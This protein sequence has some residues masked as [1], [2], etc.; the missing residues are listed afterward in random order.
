MDSEISR[1]KFNS[2]LVK[3]LG[4]V[5]ALSAM[6]LGCVTATTGA[7]KKLGV[8][9]VGLGYYSAG[10]LAPALQQTE[11]CEL[12][13]I[14]TGTPSKEKTWI[15][16][17]GIAQENIYNYD[18]FDEIVNNEAIDIVYIVLPNSMHAEFS[19]RA[20]KAGKH[21]ICEKPMAMDVAECEQI[22]KA[23]KDAGV[24]LSVGY[25]L[26]SEPYTN[27]VKRYVQDQTF[28]RP[29]YVSAEA[30]YISGN[31]W[32]QWRFNRTLSGGGALMNMG[33]YAI[34]GVLY[35]TGELPV[36]VT[37]QE[38]STNPK[39]FKETDETITAQFEF[40]SGAVANIFTSHNAQA[41]RLYATC[42]NG[43]F[44]LK[45][46]FGYGPLAGNSSAGEIRF[47]HKSQQALQMDD[48]ALHIMR[49]APNKAPG[50]MGLRDMKIVMAI[51]QSVK[52]GKKVTIDW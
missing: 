33:V 1:R 25:R 3:G 42:S 50:E 24:K 4:G 52:E 15:K 21:V 30:A 47:P 38:F 9:L 14:V 34:Q 12:R 20:A 16:K 31:N 32:N 7:D 23:C 46:A 11:H 6:P 10:L 39:K 49:D 45:P 29:L 40:P 48:F 13:G 8:A 19:I 28:G 5:V 27:E 51:Y 43:W 22:I 44:E 17:Y 2:Q 41:D 18:N 35:A 26:Q 36:S 37:A